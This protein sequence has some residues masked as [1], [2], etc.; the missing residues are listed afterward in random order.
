V[1]ALTHEAVREAAERFLGEITQRAPR[2]SAIKVD[3]KSLHKRA[4]KGELFEAPLRH[5]RLDAIT[6]VDVRGAEIDLVLTC[7]SGFY[8]RSLARDLAEALGTVGHL[9][10]LR[11]TQNGGF[12]TSEAVPFEAL[13]A[14]RGDE[15]LRPALRL[16]LRPLVE[17]CRQLPHALLDDEGARHARHGRAIALTHVREQS[18][19]FASATAL[20]AFDPSGTPLGLVERSDDQLRVLRGFHFA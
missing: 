11:R 2:V 10:R 20:V 12:S 8:V 14:A 17:V 18:P 9:S 1:P 15:R 7:G 4:R 5:V 6:I 13:R 16:R 3:G 19:S